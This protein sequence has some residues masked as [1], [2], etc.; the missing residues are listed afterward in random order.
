MDVWLGCVG[1][2]VDVYV[3]ME[4]CGSVSRFGWKCMCVYMLV[5]VCVSVCG[6]W[7]FVCECVSLSVDVW[8][9]VDVY[10]SGVCGCKYI[11]KLVD[12]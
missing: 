8:L 12:E 1:R 11:Y 4:G 6:V 5:C 10:G 7:V 2:F 3:F 9:H